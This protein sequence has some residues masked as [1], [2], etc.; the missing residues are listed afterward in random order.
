MWSKKKKIYR[1]VKVVGKGTVVT[2]SRKLRWSLSGLL[3][4]VEVKGYQITESK[5]KSSKSSN[6]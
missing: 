5:S 1:T 6:L 3:A 2:E 4:S